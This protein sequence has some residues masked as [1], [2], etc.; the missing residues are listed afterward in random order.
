MTTKTLSEQALRAA[1]DLL[2]LFKKLT[3]DVKTL[4]SMPGCTYYLIW[5]RILGNFRYKKR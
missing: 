5:G 4:F 1:N 3:F 2:A